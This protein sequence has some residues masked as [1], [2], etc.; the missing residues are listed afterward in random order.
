MRTAHFALAA[1]LV[2]AAAP[3]SAAVHFTFTGVVTSGSDNGYALPGFDSPF[4]IPPA[5][6]NLDTRETFG[7]PMGRPFSLDITVDT[8]RG[9]REDYTNDRVYYGY[10]GDSPAVAA[11]TLNGVTYTLGDP[12]DTTAYGAVERYSGPTVDTFGGFFTSTRARPPIDGPFTTFDG[13]L[14]VGVVMPTTAFTTLNFDEPVD[15]TA[16]TSSRG[17]LVINLRNTDG[18]ADRYVTAQ[19]RTANL[20][21]RFD[22]LRATVDPPALPGVPSAAPEPSAWALMIAG[23]GAAGAALR[24]RNRRT[25]SAAV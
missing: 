7:Y 22:S 20:V 21:L 17:E 6:I 25:V 4:G 13:S 10:N 12:G 2:L 5:A 23:F 16:I 9:I 11:F 1:A 18:F 14:S 24:R 19:P 15:L 8:T 3:A